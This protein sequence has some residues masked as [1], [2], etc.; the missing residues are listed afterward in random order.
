MAQQIIIKG[1]P[2]VGANEVL[3][4]DSNSKIP[5]VDGSAITTI[6]GGNIASGT[7]PTARLDTGTTAN[8]L[9]VLG[10]SGLPAVD[11]SLLT[12]IVSH[13]TS[14]SDPTVSTNP[15]GGVG[16]E[17][18]NTTSGKQFICTDATAGANVWKCSGG[19]ATGNIAPYNFGG[20]Q[21][22]YCS[23]G[24]LNG[25]WTAHQDAIQKYSYT[26]D[27]NSTDVANLLTVCG[28]CT[29]GSSQTHAY[30]HGGRSAPSQPSGINVLQKH[31]FAAGS[32]ATDVGDLATNAVHHSHAE[33]KSAWDYGFRQGG[34]PWTN[35][36]EKYSFTADGGSTDHGDMHT[37][38]S[39][40]AAGASS[41]THGYAA[42]G[43]RVPYINNIQKFAFASNVTGTD[44]GDLTRLG[45]YAAG[46][47][48]NTYGYHKVAGNAV[49]D[50]NKWA[51]ASDGNA[52]NV[53]TNS[54]STNRSGNSG[55][56]SR[57]HGYDAGGYDSATNVVNAIEKWSFTT[58]GNATDVGNLALASGEGAGCAEV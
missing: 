42:G 37:G 31:A 35:T 20:A 22:G 34:N 32:D 49:S 43:Y 17:W 56:S 1:T 48:S 50:I 2:V 25:A 28:G 19:G 4:A 36:I 27:G 41:Q 47:S 44:V 8:K 16:T 57:S 55:T 58:D 29:G 11:G 26:S 33:N 52:T 9:V 10:G 6:A 14:A 46:A 7:I 3:V 40:I 12:G 18:I 24:V 15:S 45:A 54:P 53:G 23:G 13:T 30:V 51:F 5:A 38:T 21:Y 39:G